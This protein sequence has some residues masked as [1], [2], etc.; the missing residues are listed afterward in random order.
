MACYYYRT[1]ASSNNL[2]SSYPTT[3]T[4]R[5]MLITARTRLHKTQSM[6][7]G[8]YV[9]IGRFGRHEQIQNAQAC[10]R[11]FNIV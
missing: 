7:G 9:P 11:I 6:Y 5:F 2:L 10:F 3:A 4:V 1:A 8:W